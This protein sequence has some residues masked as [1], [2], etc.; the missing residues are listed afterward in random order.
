MFG[1]K[2]L[3]VNM[4]GFLYKQRTNFGSETHTNFLVKIKSLELI[5]NW[6]K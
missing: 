2:K 4:T 5:Q 3:V 6:Q 1:N